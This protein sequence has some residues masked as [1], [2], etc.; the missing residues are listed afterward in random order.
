MIVYGSNSSN[1]SIFEKHDISN[2]GIAKFYQAFQLQ[3]SSQSSKNYIMSSCDIEGGALFKA[4]DNSSKDYFFTPKSTSASVTNE[5]SN[6]TGNI[7]S[8]VSLDE[9]NN[10]FTY[11]FTFATGS[12]S[13]GRG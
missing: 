1:N 11:R 12:T 13:E 4:T 2:L 5:Y 10:C 6:S 3:I 9:Y 7:V 8:N